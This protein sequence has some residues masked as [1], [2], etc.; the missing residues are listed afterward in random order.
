MKLET[1][2]ETVISYTIQHIP[3]QIEEG[4]GY[5]ELGNYNEIEITKVEIVTEKD[6][7]DITRYLPVSVLNEITNSIETDI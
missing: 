3:S 6:S 5:H 1:T 4:H 7:I 2:F